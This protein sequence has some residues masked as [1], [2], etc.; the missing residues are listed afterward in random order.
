MENLARLKAAN[1]SVK[2]EM[3]F[4]SSCQ[5][6]GV[7]EGARERDRGVTVTRRFLLF[8]HQPWHCLSVL[9][10]SCPS[11]SACLPRSAGRGNKTHRQLHLLFPVPFSPSQSHVI[12]LLRNIF[13][14]SKFDK[15]TEGSSFAPLA[16]SRFVFYS[17]KLFDFRSNRRNFLMRMFRHS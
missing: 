16:P 11:L 17:I 3:F 13:P 6:R 8:C 7:G 15:Q 1:L 14:I 12:F 5:M 9:L 2:S 4:R 10:S